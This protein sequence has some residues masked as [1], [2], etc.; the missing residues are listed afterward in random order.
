MTSKNFAEYLKYDPETGLLTWIKN[1]G[2]AK[3]GDVVSNVNSYGYIRVGIFYKQY[4][5]HRLAMMLSGFD[6]DGLEVDHINGI[7]TDNRL[8]NL[9]VVSHKENMQN[10]KNPYVDN[11]LGVLGVHKHG[12]RF[13]AQISIDSVQRYLGTF[14]TEKE[15]HEAYLSAKRSLHK[16][17][18]I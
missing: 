13:K 18:T 15:A 10:L 2:G 9:R 4:F 8:V 5:A 12:E 1:K 14:S 3:A 7:K 16:T 6:I 11:K 17:C